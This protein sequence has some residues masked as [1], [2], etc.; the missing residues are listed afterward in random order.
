M[1]FPPLDLRHS[2]LV[3]GAQDYLRF[4]DSAA[5]PTFVQSSRGAH[6]VS[7]ESTLI[8]DFY[9]GSGAV[10]LGHGDERQVDYLRRNL[11]HGASVSLRHPIELSVALKLRSLIP[12]IERWMFFKTGSE[13]VHLALKVAREHTKRRVVVSFGYHGWIAPF[14]FPPQEMKCVDIVEGAWDVDDARFQIRGAS[15]SLAA[16]IVSPSPYITDP[17]FYSMLREESEKCGALF[18]MDEIKSG[19]R[20]MFPCL[21]HR[22]DL[23]PDLLLLSKAIANGF[24]IAA[25]GGRSHLLDNK[26]KVSVFSTFANENMSLFAAMH[27]L[28]RLERGAFQEFATASTRFHS[29]LTEALRDHEIRLIG[30]PTFFRLELP[31]CMDRADIAVA[32]WKEQILFHPKDEVLLTAAHNDPSL[33]AECADRFVGVLSGALSP[34]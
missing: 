11:D 28:E 24:P 27:C 32:M 22:L 13:C 23:R 14:G 3:P 4:S 6:L 17:S 30:A 8:T 10:I 26:E 29:L 9:C 25:L 31:T 34:N 21:S 18:I 15:K 2:A 12:A 5:F 19:F 7:M 20:W 1:P 16:V 33:L